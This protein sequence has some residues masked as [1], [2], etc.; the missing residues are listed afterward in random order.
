MSWSNS[1]TMLKKKRWLSFGASKKQV[2]CIY[3]KYAKYRIAWAH[4]KKRTEEQSRC[5]TKSAAH[6]RHISYTKVQSAF[7][8]KN[9]T[10]LNKMFTKK[11]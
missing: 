1:W 7:I 6:R 4:N 2:W 11:S 9:M 8:Y 5:F 10:C 3:E